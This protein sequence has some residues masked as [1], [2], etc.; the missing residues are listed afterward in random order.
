MMWVRLP[1]SVLGYGNETYFLV[2]HIVYTEIKIDQHNT[3]H[4]FWIL[5]V[6]R[7]PLKN[8][9]NG[10]QRRVG[11][12]NTQKKSTQ[13]VLSKKFISIYRTKDSFFLQIVKIW[14]THAQ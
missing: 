2:S 4:H 11:C 6:P 7:A 12:L 1:S 14:Y 10:L 9:Y 8:L 5:H 3:L 13:Y